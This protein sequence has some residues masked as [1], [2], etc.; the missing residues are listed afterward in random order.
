MGSKRKLPVI[1]LTWC[2]RH[3]LLPHLQVIQE[4]LINGEEDANPEAR[5]FQRMHG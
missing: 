2:I 1:G 3:R 4:S 5:L